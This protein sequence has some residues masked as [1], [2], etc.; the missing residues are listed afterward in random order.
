MTARTLDARCSAVVAHSYRFPSLLVSHFFIRCSPHFFPPFA[1]RLRVFR[2]DPCGCSQFCHHALRY[3]CLVPILRAFFLHFSLS[4]LR[5][6]CNSFLRHFQASPFAHYPAR[7]FL[8]LHL[9]CLPLIHGS[10]PCAI[11]SRSLTPQL[12]GLPPLSSH[13]PPPGAAATERALIGPPDAVSLAC[14]LPLAWWAPPELMDTTF[15]YIRPTVPA[16]AY[17]PQFLLHMAPVVS[18]GTCALNCRRH[19]SHF[20]PRHCSLG[21]F[22]PVF[23]S[24]LPRFTPPSPDLHILSFAPWLN[25]A[26][27]CYDFFPKTSGHPCWRLLPPS[28]STW[29]SLLFL[30][31]SLPSRCL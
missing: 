14:A 12:L 30:P 9:C 10:P 13:P 2:L 24:L 8:C 26:S 18:H 27:R 15:S 6:V 19:E 11:S 31:T 22:H 5:P 7:F 20:Q 3:F 25:P 4:H 23:L 21:R 29:C 16:V 17:L 1:P 28:A